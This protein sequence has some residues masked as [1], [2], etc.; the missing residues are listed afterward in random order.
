MTQQ[1]QLTGYLLVLARDAVHERRELEVVRLADGLGLHRDDEAAALFLADLVADDLDRLLEE[2][3][4]ALLVGR[5]GDHDI[6]RR[7]DEADLDR[8]LG[9]RERLARGERR[10]D[11]EDARVRKVAELQVRADLDRLGRQPARDVGA[12]VVQDV[13]RDRELAE[14]GF[15]FTEYNLSMS[16]GEAGECGRRT[17]EAY[18]METLNASNACPHFLYNGHATI[19]FTTSMST[20]DFSATCRMIECTVFDLLYRSSHLMTSSADTR[21]LDRSMYPANPGDCQR[22]VVSCPVAASPP[23]SRHR[24]VLKSWLQ[25]A[26]NPSP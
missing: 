7:R 23:H 1:E 12:Q 3:D 4:R 22:A 17:T 11:R 10:L 24:P 5:V 20:A 8:D 9:R 16:I 6:E 19:S 21:R 13:L 15:R 26:S 18:V 2:V 14:D 25:P